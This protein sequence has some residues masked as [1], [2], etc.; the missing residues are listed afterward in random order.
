MSTF[1]PISFFVLVSNLPACKK[2]HFQV[3]CP[4]ELC[5]FS[6]NFQSESIRKVW[7]EM[8]NSSISLVSYL[9]FFQSE[10]ISFW[11]IIN[12]RGDVY[13]LLVLFWRHVLNAK[14]TKN[15]WF[16]PDWE[17]LTGL[18][19][20]AVIHSDS[21]EATFVWFEVIRFTHAHAIGLH[22]HE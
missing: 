18:F 15:L 2:Q 10:H 19:R 16:R 8:C 7:I 22:K 4:N 11:F 3:T 5:F 20:F 13:F 9:A 17:F 6:C 14:K 12:T 1:Q 21:D